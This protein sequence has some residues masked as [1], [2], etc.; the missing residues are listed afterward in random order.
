[1]KSFQ[2]IYDSNAWGNN[3]DRAPVIAKQSPS[4]KFYMSMIKDICEKYEIKSILEV[5]CGNYELMKFNIDYYN[6]NQIHYLGTDIVENNIV[7]NLKLYKTEYV[8]F[9]KLSDVSQIGFDL[10]IIKDVIQHYDTEE[11]LD[12]INTLIK[13]NKFVFCI[14]GFKFSR[15]KTKNNWTVRVLDKKYRYHPI[16]SE[17]ELMIF[18]EFE[19]E[20]KTYKMKEYILY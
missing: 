4:G 12:M 3:S 9:K 2:K 11:A 1:M 10:V 13:N 18:K 16:S 17:K 19:K 20:K 15:D 5:G 6:E 7:K 8:D 14:N